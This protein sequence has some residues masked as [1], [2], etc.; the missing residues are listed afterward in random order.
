M[1]AFSAVLLLILFAVPPAADADLLVVEYHHGAFD[2]YFI[3]PVAAEQAL[4]D[5]HAPPFQGWSRT[6]RPHRW[7]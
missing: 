5:A 3:T 2:H 7:W 1:K 6:E 4:L